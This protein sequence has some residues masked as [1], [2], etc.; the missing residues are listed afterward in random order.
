MVE[1]NEKFKKG[2]SYGNMTSLYVNSGVDLYILLF[3]TSLFGEKM[4]KNRDICDFL[5]KFQ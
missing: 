3:I 2:I 1:G 5:G 4:K